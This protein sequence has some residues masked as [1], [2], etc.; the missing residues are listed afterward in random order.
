MV[1]Y[2]KIKEKANMSKKQNPDAVI[3]AITN[4]SKEYHKV[5]IN[6]PTIRHYAFLEKMKSPFIFSDIDFG[7]ESTIPSIYILSLDRDGLKKLSGKSVE[8]IRDI[9]FDWADSTID[10][11]DVSRIIDDVVKVFTSINDTVPQ[12]TSDVTKKAKA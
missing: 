9:A 11:S 12:E 6:T 4:G 1:I 2:F 10:M 7:L 8:D 3:D 5:T